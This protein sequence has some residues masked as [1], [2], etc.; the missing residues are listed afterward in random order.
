[1]DEGQIQ[2]V[3]SFN[4]ALTRRIGVLGDNY[5]E[6]G[7]PLAESRL[8][9]E[10]G[11]DGADVRE[12]RARLSLDSGYLSRLL[13]ALEGQGLVK[14]H[15]A[16]VDA[17]VRRA[18]LTRKGL[19]EFEALDQRSQ[20]L[21]ISL[22]APLGAT[23]RTRMIEAMAE[24]E[25]LLRAAAVV[26]VPA[27]PA[28][29]DARAC[30]DAYLDELGRT[31][32]HGFDPTRGPSAEP[33][34]LVPPVGLFVLARLDDE[35]VGCG[36]LKLIARGV[37]EIKRMWVAPSARGLGV[38][39]RLLE[40]L[41]QHAAATG[42]RTLR[43]DTHRSLEAA[44]AMYLR[45]GYREIPAYNDNPYAHHWFEKRIGPQRRAS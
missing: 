30:I 25:R 11:R 45:N 4:R 32:E 43:L 10:I 9:F 23:Q 18:T 24:V 20:G 31:F 35:A 8:L 6:R 27:D 7:R 41:E 12:L 44:R 29:A 3:R 37:G 21:A 42:L 14:S 16:A 36:A 33:G 19:R 13:R 17:R 26:I 40:A 34:E 39:Q 5:L 28:S 15:P 22:L 2:Q 1:M 38:A